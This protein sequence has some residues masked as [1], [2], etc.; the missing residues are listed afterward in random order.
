MSRFTRKELAQRTGCSERTISRKAGEIP[1][2]RLRR[3]G[4]W[5]YPDRGNPN[6]QAWIERTRFTE[7]AKRKKQRMAAQRRRKKSPPSM[8]AD[9]QAIE[10]CAAAFDHCRP[11]LHKI[12]PHATGIKF[13]DSLEFD[14]WF[15]FGKLLK[16]LYDLPPPD[17]IELLIH[18][19]HGSTSPAGFKS[20][21][22]L[23]QWFWPFCNN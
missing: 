11:F 7:D 23:S 16:N 5:D 10:A 15:L 1:G 14:E 9:L 13:D 18:Y 21:F 22:E 8:L 3:S 19:F 6:T 17:R 20:L 2:A 4:K 12:Y